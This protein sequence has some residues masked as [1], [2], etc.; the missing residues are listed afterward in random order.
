MGGGGETGD[1]VLTRVR[2]AEECVGLAWL[3]TGS[4]SA[5]HHASH[6]ITP[7][8]VLKVEL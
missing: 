5:P 4:A 3:G 8:N 6:V 1:R 7:A 2:E